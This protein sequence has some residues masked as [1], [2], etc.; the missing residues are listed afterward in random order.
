M[1]G[2]A[3]GAGFSILAAVLAAL[4]FRQ[5]GGESPEPANGTAVAAKAQPDGA[6]A[7]GQEDATDATGASPLAHPDPCDGGER[8][9]DGF[10]EL[11]GFHHRFRHL[12]VLTPDPVA[13]G[14]TEALDLVAE[15]VEEA[16]SHGKDDSKPRDES[17]EEADATAYVHD[18]QWMPWTDAPRALR[19]WEK[20]PGV[21]VYRPLDGTEESEPLMVLFVG[22]TPIRGL[23]P[24]Q[25]HAAVGL[26]DR[27]GVVA[28]RDK[29]F[30]VLGPTY[31]GT[32]ASLAAV[33]RSLPEGRKVRIV[34]GTAMTVK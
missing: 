6:Q 31:S 9:L 15:G 8:L 5:A 26:I 14:G 30:L 33:I 20:Q 25:F 22:E 12:I 1:R 4:S 21:I 17:E 11:Y 27:Y 28:G 16:V 23:R 3:G 10:H 13:M 29:P 18:T 24:D 19:C 34:S 2:L 7:P 32:A